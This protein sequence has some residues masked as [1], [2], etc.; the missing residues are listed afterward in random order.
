[1]PINIW[2]FIVKSE[3]PVS[4]R[5]ICSISGADRPFRKKLR[6][7][8]SSVIFGLLFQ[9]AALAENLRIEVIRLQNRSA[10]EIQGL[11]TPLLE[12]GE[13]LTGNDFDLIVKS[14]PERQETIRSLIKQLDTRR[15]NLIITV[16]NN[17]TKSAE[18]LNAEAAIQ[19]SSQ[20]IRMQGILG[21]TRSM[22][23]Q[24][25]IQQLRTLEGQP[26]HIQT[27]TIR[28]IN[29]VT[30]YDSGYGYPAIMSN[31]QMQEASSGFAAMPRL[32]DDRN[33]II[34]IAPWSDR[35]LHSAGLETQAIQS[36]IR[37][38]LGEWVELG[39]VMQSQQ[40]QHQGFTGLNHTTR[41]QD[42]HTL[43]KIDRVD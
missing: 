14:N 37:T 18:Q 16:L 32:V 1:M 19:A 33:V 22:D 4:S 10:D 34:D 21:D 39:G 20:G 42:T 2:H 40:T 35:F 6:L 15:H 5:R 31:P 8:L 12:S 9:Q 25:N 17:S 26:A 27:G 11:V 36:T 23:S 13:A 7:V 38:R 28:L 24:R 29:N 43:I 30:V 3:Q 41:N